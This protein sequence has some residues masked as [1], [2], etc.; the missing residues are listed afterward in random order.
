MSPSAP[1]FTRDGIKPVT[2]EGFLKCATRLIHRAGIRMDPRLFRG[3]SPRAGGAT[4]LYEAGYSDAQ[5]KAS[6][7]WLSDAYTVYTRISAANIAE[8]AR[9]M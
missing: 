3:I 2:R 5:I 8:A 4:D 7:R 1:L 9:H 6:G